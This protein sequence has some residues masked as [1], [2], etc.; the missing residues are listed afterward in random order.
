M[1]LL[2]SDTTE[3][4][5]IEWKASVAAQIFRCYSFHLLFRDNRDYEWVDFSNLTFKNLNLKDHLW[6]NYIDL[7]NSEFSDVTMRNVSL[8]NANLRDTVFTN[9]YMPMTDLR[10][11]ILA[12]ATFEDLCFLTGVNFEGADLTNAK[13]MDNDLRLTNFSHTNLKGADFTGAQLAQANFDFSNW[14]EA[15]SFEGIVDSLVNWGEHGFS[16]FTNPPSLEEKE[17][18]S[19]EWESRRRNYFNVLMRL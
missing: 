19:K 8:R 1:L 10:A 16:P 5:G 12:D 9:V 14:W 13:L 3:R 4:K 11:A 6:L 17:R 15:K 18:L 7:S 2:F